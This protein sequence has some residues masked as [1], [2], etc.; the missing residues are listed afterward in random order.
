MWRKTGWVDTDPAVAAVRQIGC[1]RERESWP[2]EGEIFKSCWAG[3]SLHQL[4]PG[5]LRAP[6]AGQQQDELEGGRWGWG[7]NPPC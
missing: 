7:S 3:A 6:T 2:D 4:A 5:G 1:V